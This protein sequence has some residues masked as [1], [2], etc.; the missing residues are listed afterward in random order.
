MGRHRLS[1]ARVY[2]RPDSPAWWCWAYD[3][4]GKLRRMTTRCV[5]REAA[6]AFVANVEREI[7]GKIVGA[8][9]HIEHAPKSFVY[10]VQA[11][12]D[13]PIK[14][15]RAETPTIRVSKLQISSP[16]ELRI[17]AV[18]P[19]GGMLE[20]IIQLA[21]ADDLMRGEWFRPSKRLNRLIEELK[22]VDDRPW[23]EPAA[24]WCRRCGA[25][26]EQKRWAFDGTCAECAQP[27]VGVKR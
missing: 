14:I 16:V 3:T 4:D 26:V 2:K 11:G 22:R 12:E 15:G 20:S 6:E 25:P 19:G 5:D 7:H 9:L 23:S 21:F 27:A 13:G 17:V 24:P 10:F 8:V 18:V 1:N